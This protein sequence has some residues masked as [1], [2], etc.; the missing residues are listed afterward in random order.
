MSLPGGIRTTLA[1]ALLLIVGGALGGAYLM[2]V[3][4]LERHLVDDRARRAAARRD[5][6]RAGRT[7]AMTSASRSRTTGFV[8]RV[9]IRFERARGGLPGARARRH[10]CGT[11]ADSAATGGPDQRGHRRARGRAHLARSPADASTRS[12]PTVRRGGRPALLGERAP[13]LRRR[14]R[15]SSRRC[16]SS[17][18][19]CSTR[20]ASR[21]RSPRSS[22]APLRRSTRGGSAGSSGPAN[23]IAE[24]QFD[25]P[26]VDLRRRRARRAGS[27]LRA[28]ARPARAARHGAEGVRRQRL[29]RAPHAAVLARGL[30]RA[31]GRRGPRRR[32]AR[33]VPR[34]DAGAGRPADEARGRPARPVADRRRAAARRAGGGR[35]RG[36]GA[37]RWSTSS[38]RSPRRPAT[39]SCWRPIRRPGRS[40]TR[41]AC[42]RSAA[43]SR[44]TRSRTRPRGR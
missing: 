42:S 7:H 36:R 23:R 16:A 19:G 34:D 30:P 6:R 4:S 10:R 15:T 12:G 31:H 44:A 17:S 13:A 37:V 33:R 14:S 35:P 3:P 5:H 20:Q 1:V 21:S 27:R 8:G 40:P 11:I 2:V 18:G 38:R 25:E 24:G 32:D 43:R 28:D 39:G 26:V 41:S 29:A 9:R 22:A